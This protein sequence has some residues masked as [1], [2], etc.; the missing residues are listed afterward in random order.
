MPSDISQAIEMDQIA[1]TLVAPL[2]SSYDDTQDS[3]SDYRHADDGTDWQEQPQSAEE[4]Q[5]PE[6]AD[7]PTEE[8]QAEWMQHN[9][10]FDSLPEAQQ[11]EQCSQL[12]SE[13]YEQVQADLDPQTC[14]EWA[15]KTG[16]A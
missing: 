4:S 5:E 6:V 2:H 9:E 14:Q 8:Q 11:F 7:A 10:A 1:E 13:R 3:G 15:Q 12:L 16:K